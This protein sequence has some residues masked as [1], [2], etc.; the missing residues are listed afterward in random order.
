MSFLNFGFSDALMAG[1]EASGYKT[2][3]P[4]QQSVI[5]MVLDQNDVIG[6]AP[7]GTGKTAAFALPIIDL[8][9]NADDLKRVKNPRVL[10]LAPT[11]ELAV[12][13]KDCINSYN[14][15]VG[16]RSTVVYGGVSI[17]EQI[18]ELK[19]GTHVVIAT[20]GRLLDIMDRGCINLSEINML[21]LDEADR[22]YDMGFIND[23]R[24]IIEA[25][26]YDRQTLLFSATMKDE[27]RGLIS[28][29]QRPDAKFV[30]IGKTFVP[31]DQIQQQAISVSQK[32][33]QQLLEHLIREENVQRM[34]VFSRTKHGADRIARSLLM[35][36]ISSS[37]LHSDRS[38]SQRRQALDGFKQQKY[39]VLVATDVA[40]R[41]IDVKGITHVVNFDTPVFAEDYIH[42]IGRTGRA[43]AEG[44]AL[45]FV[46]PDEEQYLK[47]IQ[48]FTGKR[49]ALTKIPG[50][51][52]EGLSNENVKKPFFETRK[53]SYYRK[54][55]FAR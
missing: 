18:R 2:P 27:I 40:A 46:S 33:K 5:P 21:V 37:A 7:T 12:Q 51:E 15:Y 53:R 19:K 13:I 29:I 55:S 26:P 24:E 8:L 39:R 10:I 47:R 41:G 38:Q 20:P 34:L 1:I 22:M 35:G 48:Y 31:V 30:E 28:E 25:I 3:T 52:D 42:R 23:V 14:Q 16:I 11:R 4:I 43:E 17:G 45:T 54:P 49:L 6:C 44:I 9:S 50:F 36:G 32:K